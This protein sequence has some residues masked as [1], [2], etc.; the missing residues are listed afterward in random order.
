[1][2]NFKGFNLR[3]EEDGK[4]ATLPSYI[5]FGNSKRCEKKNWEEMKGEART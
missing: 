2:G 1:M 4:E 5:K 3:M